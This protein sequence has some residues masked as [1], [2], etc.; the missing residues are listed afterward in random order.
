MVHGDNSG[1]KLPPLV[2]PTQV[3]IVPIKQ[4][5]EG[6]LD[7][8]YELRDE[9]KKNKHVKSFKAAPYNDGGEGCTVVELKDRK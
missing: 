4:K 8:A 2:A 1:L 7:K 5:A 6:V 9:L 3:V